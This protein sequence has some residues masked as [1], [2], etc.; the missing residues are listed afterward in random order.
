MDGSLK[1]VPDRMR[2]C[3]LCGQPL[4]VGLKIRIIGFALPGRYLFLIDLPKALLRDVAL[5]RQ[6]RRAFLVL[7]MR[8]V[9]IGQICLCPFRV[10]LGDALK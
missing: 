1:V 7:S 4:K 2:G 10:F 5:A 6:R 3:L 8:N 9:A